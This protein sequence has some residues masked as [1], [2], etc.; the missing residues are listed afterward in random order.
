[1]VWEYGWLGIMAPICLSEDGPLRAVSTGLSIVSA[2]LGVP[3][4]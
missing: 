2:F 3:G 4:W 1:M